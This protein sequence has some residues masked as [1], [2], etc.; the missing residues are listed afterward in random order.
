MV[1]GSW[2][3]RP[4]GGEAGRRLSGGTPTGGCSELGQSRVPARP[5]EGSSAQLSCVLTNIFK[6]T[7]YAML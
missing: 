6:V 5:G 7:S 4:R 1:V 3:R 2:A